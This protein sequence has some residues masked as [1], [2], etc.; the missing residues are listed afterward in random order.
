[1]G[2]NATT[3][4][5]ASLTAIDYGQ[6]MGFDDGTYMDFDINGDLRILGAGVYQLIWWSRQW[7][8]G[9]N[10]ATSWQ[11][12]ADVVSGSNGQ[13]SPFAA[14]QSAG[15]AFGAVLGR[16]EDGSGMDS[17]DVSPS[18]D[19]I[20]VAGWDT[21]STFPVIIRTFY[22]HFINNVS[23]AITQPTF[24]LHVTRLGDAFE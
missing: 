22:E 3:D 2:G 11:V 21:S 17:G 13:W 23:T 6:N 9:A 10:V 16:A 4:L 19:M 24:G 1:M 12:F 15:Q 7:V 5:A 20:V 8:L 18:P 14:G